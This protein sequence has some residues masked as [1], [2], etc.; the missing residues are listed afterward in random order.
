MLCAYV[1]ALLASVS[2]GSSGCYLVSMDNMFNQYKFFSWNVRGLN[3]MAMQH[4]VRQLIATFRP[5]LLC[6]QVTKMTTMNSY[7]VRNSLGPEYEN[8]YFMLPE[9]GVAFSLL[10][11]QP[12]FSCTVPA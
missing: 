7:V 6:I 5:D 3:S 2:L 9:Q 8:N 10:L 12:L 4:D 1:L 11:T